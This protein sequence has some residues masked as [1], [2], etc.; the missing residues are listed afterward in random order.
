MSVI[1]IET[2]NPSDGSEYLLDCNV[3]MYLFYQNG[4]YLK[5]TVEKYSIFLTQIYNSDAKIIL[6]DMVISE[7]TNTYIQMEFQR[8]AKIN[9]WPS[10]K[11]YFKN[12]FKTTNEYEDILKEIKIIIERQLMPVSIKV[13]TDFVGFDIASAFAPY[14]TFDF[15]DR[16]YSYAMKKR[17]AYIV[18]NDADFADLSGCNVITCNQVLL[19]SCT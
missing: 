6:T 14:A 17:G 10:D 3:L 4:S 2:F 11:A 15:N 5:D 12:T 13:N 9:G 19:S 7:F 18:T 1:D 8:L 16:F